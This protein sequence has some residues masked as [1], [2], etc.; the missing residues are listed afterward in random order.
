MILFIDGPETYKLI[1]SISPKSFYQVKYQ[2]THSSI[3]LDYE[4]WK[5][6]NKVPYDIHLWRLTPN[7]S[8]LW[9]SC[10][11]QLPQ[12]I[13]DDIEEGILNRLVTLISTM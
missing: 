5:T 3:L 10:I 12:N 1:T 6:I 9:E 7:S 13:V 2:K 4:Y 11:K 8:L